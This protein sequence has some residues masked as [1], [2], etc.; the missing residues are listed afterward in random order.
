MPVPVGSVTEF[1]FVTVFVLQY[2]RIIREPKD[3]RPAD[4]KR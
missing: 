3:I 2:S 1:C 4:L